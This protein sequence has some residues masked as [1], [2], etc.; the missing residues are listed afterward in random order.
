[1][2][3]FHGIYTDIMS[4]PWSII[5][6]MIDFSVTA[7]M[8]YYIL[9]YLRGTRA[10]SVL[11]GLIIALIVLSG[12]SISLN[13]YVLSIIF[14]NLWT[15]I[16]T[17]LVVIFQPEL[18]RAFAQL[19]SSTFR[20]PSDTQRK[21]ISEVVSAVQQL[22]RT[23]TGALIVFERGIGMASIKNSAV[24]LSAQVN[25]KLLQSIF[26][27]NSPLHD[28]ALIIRGDIIEAAHAILPLTTQPEY[29]DMG[30]GTRH[31]AA[32]GVTEETDA[33]AVVVSEE[34]GI[35]SVAVKD[36]FERKMTPAQLSDFLTRNIL[37]AHVGT[38]NVLSMNS[39]ADGGESA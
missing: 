13:L 29:S 12:L 30:L 34:T 25:S 20:H 7:L 38:Q 15:I 2:T 17:A 10:A 28:G 35:I 21:T 27:P 23:K 36:R 3:F 31:R 32:I 33:I 22:S 26:Y 4:D 14:T 24:P 39:P 11:T 9:Y 1:M 6:V 5:R 16:A 37:P 18:R 19:G 8:I